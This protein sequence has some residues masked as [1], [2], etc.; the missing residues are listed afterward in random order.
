M[1]PFTRTCYSDQDNIIDL[2]KKIVGEAFKEI[3]D[4]FSV[5]LSQHTE[6]IERVSEICSR[7]DRML[8]FAA[9]SLWISQRPSSEPHVC[10]AFIR[11]RVTVDK[12]KV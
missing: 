12:S 3:P 9:G 2:A 10:D 11:C 6:Q 7:S 5:R 1:I 8:S 4:K